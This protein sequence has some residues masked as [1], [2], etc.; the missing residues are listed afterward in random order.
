MTTLARESGLTQD[1]LRD[2]LEKQVL[3]ARAAEWE[4]KNESVR[5]INKKLREKQDERFKRR[6][7]G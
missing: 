4:A 1:E 2:Y 5:K 6:G 7:G 3:A